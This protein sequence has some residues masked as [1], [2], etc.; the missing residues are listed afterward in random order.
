MQYRV[1]MS[2]DDELCK[3]LL[4]F[5][6]AHLAVHGD[7]DYGLGFIEDRFGSTLHE[8]GPV[9][10]LSTPWWH[11]VFQNL[12][13][14]NDGY[15][16]TVIVNVFSINA[17][18]VT[19][20]SQ[21][22][23][24]QPD[25]LNP[26]KPLEGPHYINEK[27]PVLEQWVD[28]AEGGSSVDYV[29]R[30]HPYLL[31]K[32]PGFDKMFESAERGKK[33]LREDRDPGMIVELPAIGQSVSQHIVLL[34][35]KVFVSARERFWVPKSKILLYALNSARMIDDTCYFELAKHGK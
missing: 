30:S 4:A 15:V 34:Q 9:F 2:E 5:Y 23:I 32:Y 26:F 7:G 31:R 3:P 11:Q 16:Q 17:Q 10:L 21:L 27:D 28:F 12:D 24:I 8:P 13:I 20:Q 33:L 22:L 19:L 1:V 18:L 6:N 35:G 14:Y 29:G 25:A